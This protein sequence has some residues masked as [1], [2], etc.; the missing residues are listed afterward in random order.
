MIVSLDWL[1]EFVDI[2]ESPVELAELLSGIG[3]EAEVTSVPTV[4]WRKNFSQPIDTDL[5]VN[6]VARQRHQIGLPLI[7][8]QGRTSGKV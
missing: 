8:A 1:K 6:D 2:Q 5:L 4:N 7:R 3:L